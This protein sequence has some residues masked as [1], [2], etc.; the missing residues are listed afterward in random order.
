M[1]AASKAIYLDYAATTPVRPEVFD[2][3]RPFFTERFGNPSS[4]HSF[5]QGARKGMELARKGVAAVL[6]AEANE[7]V[8]TAGG[9]EADNL[10]LFGVARAN[11]ERGKH[12]IVS[13]IEHSAIGTS[14][15]T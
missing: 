9:S 5:G 14:A 13:S 15:K 7:I 12:I 11:S 8:F 6:G 2:A 4:L 1:P 3:M 10:A